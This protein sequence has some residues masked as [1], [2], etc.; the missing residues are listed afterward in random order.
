MNDV[1]QNVLT[2]RQVFLLLILSTGLI[3][4]VMIIPNLLYAAGRDAW[5]SVLFTL[6]AYFLFL[7]ILLF[8]IKYVKH[9]HIYEW[10]KFHFGK[11]FATIY[12]LPIFLFLFLNTAVTLKDTTLWLNTYFLA[13]SPPIVGILLLSFVSFIGSFLGIKILA[14][15]AGIILPTVVLLG[16]L[17]MGVNTT[18]KNPSLLLPLFEN[19]YQPSLNGIVY[20]SAG[21]LEIFLVILLLPYIKTPIRYKHLFIL[22]VILVGLI[23]GPLSAA[24]ME[25]GPI[26]ASNLRYP[27]YEQWRLLRVGEYISNMDFFAL[28][29][30]MSGAF[31]RIS[32]FMYLLQTL[33]WKKRKWLLFIGGYVL[34]IATSMIPADY[35]AFNTFLYTYYFKGMTFFLLGLTVLTLCLAFIVKKRS[36]QHEKKTS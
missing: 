15:V 36:N 29:Q 30:W 6:P 35:F 16:F 27:A 9:Q 7:Y 32:L 34:L 2:T 12:I 26:E 33:V 10:C 4:H 21:L 3:N 13:E 24:I 1:G 19:G 28:Y 31:I 18:E 11:V 22:G 17:I 8:I 20:V 5:V 14:I 25:Y 23:L